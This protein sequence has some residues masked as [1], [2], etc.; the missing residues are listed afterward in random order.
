MKQKMEIYTNEFHQSEHQAWKEVFD[1]LSEM[2]SDD[3]NKNRYDELFALIDSWGQENAKLRVWQKETG[4]FDVMT[5]D[6]R[7]FQ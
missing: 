7:I 6:G 5:E 3:C 4:Q 1:K 2:F